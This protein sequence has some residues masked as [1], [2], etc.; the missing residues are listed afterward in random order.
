MSNKKI[1][2]SMIAYR[3]RYLE[4][5]V[6]SCYLSAKYPENLI[7]S[8]VS[9]QEKNSLHATLN[10]IPVDQINYIKYDL[11]EYRGVLWSRAK[12][13]EIA[14]EIEFDYVLYTCGHNRFTKNWDETSVNIYESLK[15]K[16]K[17]PVLTIA[18][19]SFEVEADGSIVSTEYSNIYRPQLNSD[20]T[21]GYGFPSQVEVPNLPGEFEDVYLQFSW[22]FAERKF[23][24]D[25]PLDPDMNYHGEEIYVTIQA[26]SRGW[27]FFTTSTI[28]YQHDTNKSYVDEV[29]PRMTTHRPWSDINKDHFWEQSDRSM[30]K[31]NVLLSGNARGAYGG[32]DI[33]SIN[34]YCDFSGLSREWCIYDTNYDKLSKDR[35]AQFFRNR[36]PFK[37]DPS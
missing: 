33:K 17:K 30:L 16:H 31:L 22:V 19:P 9:E 35:H 25:V 37:L 4:E 15:V 5:S 8:V 23:I 29:L 27:R 36:E 11:S 28:L 26:W 10:F 21:P 2:V 7:F 12:T 1:L 13:I 14:H 20:Y 32:I 6:K 3:E 34:E 24:E 18:G